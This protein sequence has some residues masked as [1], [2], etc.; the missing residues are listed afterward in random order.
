MTSAI[1]TIARTTTPDRAAGQPA[2][3]SAPPGPSLLRVIGI[4]ARS[5]PAALV[6]W[7]LVAGLMHWHLLVALG[8][9]SLVWMV[10][11]HCLEPLPEAG[12]DA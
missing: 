10:G 12:E 5:L 8:F 6:G 2:D 1:T 3:E 11:M 4:V 9:A 7:W